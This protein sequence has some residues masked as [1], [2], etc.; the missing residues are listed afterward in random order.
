MKL[1]SKSAIESDNSAK[2][3]SR[4]SRGDSWPTLLNLPESRSEDLDDGRRGVVGRD[5]GRRLRDPDRLV[6]SPGGVVE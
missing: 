2:A 1:A 3:G 5:V 6:V 4:A